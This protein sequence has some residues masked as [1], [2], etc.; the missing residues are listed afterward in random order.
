MKLFPI[1]VTAAAAVKPSFELGE[2][3]G[4]AIAEGNKH[5]ADILG[6][7]SVAHNQKLEEV[8]AAENKK[9]SSFVQRPVL[10]L[11]VAETR[12][13]FLSLEQA[14]TRLSQFTSMLAAPGD[15]QRAGAESTSLSQ[16]ASYY[17]S[18]LNAGGLSAR[19]GLAGLL[20]L[21]A[22]PN[23]RALLMPSVRKASEL[24]KRESTP[25][26]TRNLAG[27]LITFLTN[28]PVAFTSS[29]AATGAYGHTNIVV[30][31]PSRVYSSF[32]KYAPFDLPA[33]I[34]TDVN[35][36]TVR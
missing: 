23:A 21:A 24:A 17:G 35:K 34:V 15:I 25:D 29:D 19:K 13:S 4:S 33:E 28:T 16:A 30:P 22:N 10:N 12:A 7:P 8:V 6:E 27:S 20:K 31:A 14:D 32:L 18:M 36:G 1:F 11:H 5:A 3:I 26:E 2:K 9:F